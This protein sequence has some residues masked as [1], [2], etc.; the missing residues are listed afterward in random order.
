MSL[1]KRFRQEIEVV[2]C[3]LGFLIGPRLPYSW[4]VTLARGVGFTAYF[5]ISSQRQIALANL[6]LALGN[7]KTA[8]ERRRIARRSFQSFARTGFESLA[9]HHLLREEWKQRFEFAPR[10]LDLLEQLVGRKRGLI[11]LTFHY[12]NWEWLSLA[13]GMAGYPVIA[14]AQPIKNPK[15]ETIF[16]FNR[17]HAG[18]HLLHRSPR[19]GIARQLYKVLK[20]RKTI[21]LLV[22]LNSSIEEGGRFFDFFGLPAMTTRAVGLLALR[23]RAPIVCSVAYP[24]EDGRYRIEIGP[25]IPYNLEAHV[26]REIDEITQRWL[27]YCEKAV[28]THPEYWMWMYKRW[29]VRPT[30]EIG[31]YPFY[32]FYDPKLNLRSR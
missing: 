28:R 6:E 24:Q 8:K 7:S 27:A 32:S 22:D 2:F 13:W 11:A 1:W 29:K 31:R 20:Q 10:S 25:E 18:H 5:L 3:R 21:G 16:R 14:V 17:E 4:L 19:G 12:G 30:P 23:T 9:S 26:E 15:V